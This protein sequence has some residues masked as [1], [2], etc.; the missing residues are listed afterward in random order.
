MPV[1]TKKVKKIIMKPMMK[2]DKKTLKYRIGLICVCAVT[3]AG[4]LYAVSRSYDPLARYPYATEENRDVILMYLDE[5]DIDYLVTSQLEPEEFLPFITLPEFDVHNARLYTQAMAVQPE[6]GSMI[7]HFIN[8]YRDELDGLDLQAL[9]KNY[10]YQD[11]S[12]W[13]DMEQEDQLIAE[14]SDMLALPGP[15]RSVWTYVPRDLVMTDHVYLN[16][17]AAGA[18]Q[19]MA[20]DYG[21]IM[22][23]DPFTAEAGYMSYED[24]ARLYEQYPDKVLPAGENEL[25]LGYTVGVEGVMDWLENEDGQ[26][27]DDAKELAD[28]LKE[29]A[30]RYGFVVRY[31]EDKEKETGHKYDP[32]LVRYVGADNA[33]KLY[34]NN[35][36][37]EELL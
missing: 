20:R 34:E 11:L 29:N 6:E 32:F 4:C 9:L 7:V 30:W 17:E 18:F 15:G 24:A 5:N 33:R 3:A 14:P 21:R 2:L 27:D 28:W 37:L 8:R 13:F 23:T 31:P 10:S 1:F 36:V 22:E 25:Q 19:A 12:T 16:S 26:V 35:Q